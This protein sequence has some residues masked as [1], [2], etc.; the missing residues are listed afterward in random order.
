MPS[1]RLSFCS[2]R[3]ALQVA[4]LALVACG[5]TTTSD[6]PVSLASLD[7]TPASL[8]LNTGESG[9]FTAVP[10]SGTGNA[11]TA[12]AVTWS[13]GAPGIASVTNAGA[14]T[15][16]GP[17]TATL[18]A[19]SSGVSKQVT[20]TVNARP[21]ISV[22]ATNVSFTALQNA[23]AAPSQQTVSV[24]N[25]GGGS[26]TGLTLSAVTFAAG[27]PTGWV[28]PAPSLTTTSAPASVAVNVSQGGRTPGTYNASFQILSPTADN[29]P[30][31]VNVTMVV[32]QTFQVL[33]SGGTT[34]PDARR[35]SG[36][37]VP[38][39]GTFTCTITNGVAAGPACNLVGAASATFTLT[40][41]PATGSAFA[42]WDSATVKA[43]GSNCNNV[44]A[45]S[46]SNTC[47]IPITTSSPSSQT[48]TAF[49]CRVSSISVGQTITG[50]F[51]DRSSCPLVGP[52]NS[53]FSDVVSGAMDGSVVD[54]YTFTI[55][56]TAN[57]TVSVD[58]TSNAS[59]LRPAVWV[60]DPQ[61]AF[62]A[63]GDVN[64]GTGSTS[65]LGHVS[66]NLAPG[67]YFIWANGITASDLGSYTLSLTI[68]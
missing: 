28:T 40:A 63:Y 54:M 44:G 62:K 64:H 5:E 19:T 45:T 15:A 34:T 13:S 10:K 65:T 22:S 17:G 48:I 14:V 30:L 21:H 41:T 31:T 68:R 7:V 56:G 18:T 33:V 38:S 11:L 59:T 16:I 35:G 57:V 53:P 9:Q 42:F 51:L 32:V 24:T 61:R 29:S 60:V 36:T 27:Q 49:F 37:V 47:N 52:S 6:V 20:V 58:M 25:T 4:L 2:S 3:L 8:T 66:V 67:T 1:S 50:N 46:S 23:G 39:P 12:R 55:G 43:L 26:L